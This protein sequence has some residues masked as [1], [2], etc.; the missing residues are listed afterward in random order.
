MLLM[1][2]LISIKSS[3]QRAPIACLTVDLLTYLRLSRVSFLKSIFEALYVSALL[4]LFVP[5]SNSVKA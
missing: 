5:H 2:S 4:F 1:N 3:V